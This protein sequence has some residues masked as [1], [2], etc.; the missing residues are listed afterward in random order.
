MN[1]VQEDVGMILYYVAKFQR[2]YLT[3]SEIHDFIARVDVLGE[4]FKDIK[5]LTRQLGR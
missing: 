4:W 2:G 5:R 3:N 1:L